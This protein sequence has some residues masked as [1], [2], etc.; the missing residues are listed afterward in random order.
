MKI[1]PG[2]SK[3]KKKNNSK[4]NFFSKEII[5]YVALYTVYILYMSISYKYSKM[6]VGLRFQFSVAIPQMATG[7]IKARLSTAASSTSNN[8]RG[9]KKVNCFCFSFFFYS[10]EHEVVA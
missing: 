5:P 10:F 8:V 6:L 2:K 7:L 1:Q 3:K 4:K 9:S